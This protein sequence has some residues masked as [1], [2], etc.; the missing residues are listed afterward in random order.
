MIDDENLKKSK[1]REAAE[2][3]GN[4]EEQNIILKISASYACQFPILYQETQPL[5]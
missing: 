5:F 3:F 4:Q 2:R 1:I